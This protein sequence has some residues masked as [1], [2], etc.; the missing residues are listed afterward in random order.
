MRST[1]KVIHSIMEHLDTLPEQHGEGDY[2][3]MLKIIA[4]THNMAVNKVMKLCRTVIT[5][6]KVYSVVMPY[7]LEA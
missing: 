4:S 5:G 6:G 2:D 7:T 3:N 1:V